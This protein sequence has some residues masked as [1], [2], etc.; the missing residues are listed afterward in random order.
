MIVNL[1]SHPNEPKL[2]DAYDGVLL[3]AYNEDGDGIEYDAF[4]YGD[5]SWIAASIKKMLD[6]NPKIREYLVALDST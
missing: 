5:A 3:V 6:K 1:K 2:A 4:V